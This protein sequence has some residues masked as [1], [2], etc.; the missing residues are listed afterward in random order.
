M[1]L[2]IAF[3][4]TLYNDNKAFYSILLNTRQG[5]PG[6]VNT[7]QLKAGSTVNILAPYSVAMSSSGLLGIWSVIYKPFVTT[8]MAMDLEFPIRRFLGLREG[9]RESI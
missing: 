4:C 5:R 6:I 2:L 8:T 3:R 1:E 9:G 7:V